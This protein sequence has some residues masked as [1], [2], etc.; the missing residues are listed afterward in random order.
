VTPFLISRVSYS[1]FS[2][3]SLHTTRYGNSDTIKAKVN[4]F[5][6]YILAFFSRA[7]NRSRS[8]SSF[9]M[10]S[11]SLPVSS[12]NCSQPSLNVAICSKHGSHTRCPIPTV[13]E[14]SGTH[15]QIREFRHNQGESERLPHGR[16][17]LSP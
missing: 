17:S 11:L 9:S 7:S 6:E 10:P 1:S 8:Y 2:M 5:H 3:P 14:K 12:I 4:A 16:R 13:E 15:N